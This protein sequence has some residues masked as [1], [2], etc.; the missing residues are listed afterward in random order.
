MDI[1]ARSLATPVGVVALEYWDVCIGISTPARPDSIPRE[2]LMRLPLIR[3]AILSQGGQL[4]PAL[5]GKPALSSAQDM[6]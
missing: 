1:W 5:P 6:H 3:H 2:A 4:C